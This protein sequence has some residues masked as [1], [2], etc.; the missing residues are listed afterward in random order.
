MIHIRFVTVGKIKTSWISEGIDHFDK[1]LS[2]YATLSEIT[3]KEEKQAGDD[4]KEQVIKAESERLL[5]TIKPDSVT[6]VLDERGN[7][8]TSP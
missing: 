6:V 3:V 2:R 7:V 8:M 4:K 1:L 5:A